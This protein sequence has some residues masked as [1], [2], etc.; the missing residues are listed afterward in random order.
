MWQLGE[1]G[2]WIHGTSLY[3]S[4]NFV[5]DYNYSK[6][7]SLKCGSS[8][9]VF[10][11]L[12]TAQER[13][14]VTFFLHFTKWR[15]SCE[16][17]RWVYVASGGNKRLPWEGNF[18]VILRVAVDGARCDLTLDVFLAMKLVEFTDKLSE[19][20]IIWVIFMIEFSLLK[21]FSRL[22]I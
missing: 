21:T 7:Q 16:E 15:L 6:I 1:V 13:S 22:P 4:G 9:S 8:C 19:V 3:Y 20:W 10:Q 5:W 11:W 2:L 14:P 17:L 18:L 12:L